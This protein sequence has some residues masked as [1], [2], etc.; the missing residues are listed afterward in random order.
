MFRLISRAIF[1]LGKEKEG[2]KEIDE[3][4]LNS[5]LGILIAS[6]VTHQGKTAFKY[7]W[8]E[9]LMVPSF[10]ATVMAR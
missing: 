2:F 7:L 10:F 6:G 8:N 4:E 9:T 3:I 1:F 5:F